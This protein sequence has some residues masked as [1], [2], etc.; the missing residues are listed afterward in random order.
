VEH[1]WIEI[2]TEISL[3]VDAEDRIPPSKVEALF[4][5]HYPRLQKIKAQY[6]PNRVFSRWFGIEPA[7]AA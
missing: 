2:G 7:A 6:D 5:D 4:K 1:S 3:F